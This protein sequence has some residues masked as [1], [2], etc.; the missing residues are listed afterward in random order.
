[1]G[2]PMISAFKKYIKKTP[3]INI[4][5]FIKKQFVKPLAQNDETQIIKRL[6]QRFD[7]PRSFIE[8]GFSG[9]EFNCASL[10]S[11]WEGLL[12]DGDPYNVKIADI[13]CPKTITA[14]CSWLTLESLGFICDYAKSKELGILSIDVDGND[15]WF[16]EELIATKPAIII[17][18]YN[19]SFGL[20]PITVPYDPNFDRTKK[21][22]SWM[23]FGASLSAINH[24][25]NQ[26]GYSL[27]EVSNS[28]VNAF[29]VRKDLLTIDDYELKPECSFREKYFSDGSRPSQQWEKIKH[30]EYVDVT[31]LESKN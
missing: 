2:A 12:V 25:A 1:M 3:L 26:N 28:G 8:F 22:E 15:Y 18:E 30:L 11:N 6:I 17:A 9:W 13:I 24:L 4:F 27:I 19:S 5:I 20:K 31:K 29:F 7:V 16:L 10:I 21:H 23:Y 14:K